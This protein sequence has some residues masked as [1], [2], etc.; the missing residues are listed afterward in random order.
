MI[1]NIMYYTY[2]SSQLHWWKAESS[3]ERVC[4]HWRLWRMYLVLKLIFEAWWIGVRRPKRNQ[5]FTNLNCRTYS[6]FVRTSGT[7]FSGYLEILFWLT[8][9]YP[10]LYPISHDWKPQVSPKTPFF[11]LCQFFHIFQ[12]FLD[13]LKTCVNEWGC[14]PTIFYRRITCKAYFILRHRKYPK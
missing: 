3:R 7:I 14:T 12:I 6:K 9:T 2:Y 5:K 4:V 8:C 13:R 10:P 11:Q 1:T